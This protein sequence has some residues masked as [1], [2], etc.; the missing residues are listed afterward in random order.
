MTLPY[1]KFS[2]IFVKENDG[3]ISFEWKG[4]SYLPVLIGENIHL[5]MESVDSAK[6]RGGLPFE[7][8]E[9]REIEPDPFRRFSVY[10]R[11]DIPHHLKIIQF[12][13]YRWMLHTKAFD[14][15]QGRFILRLDS[16][17]FAYVP[18][19]EIPHWGCVGRRRPTDDPSN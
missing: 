2:Q 12:L 1:P 3:L 7:L 15:M 8:F 4:P 18:W 16:L 14:K 17:G 9:L 11:T 19:Y 6:V 5:L 13:Q 10:L